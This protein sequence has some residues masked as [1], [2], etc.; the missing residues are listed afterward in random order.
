MIQN[1]PGTTGYTKMTQHEPDISTESTIPT[2]KMKIQPILIQ[3]E[4]GSPR[5]CLNEYST[6]TNSRGAWISAQQNKNLFVISHSI[7]SSFWGSLRCV[8]ILQLRPLCSIGYK[9]VRECENIIYENRELSIIG[10]GIR[11][12]FDHRKEF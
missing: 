7:E 1:D 10:F 12:I 4:L 6:N 9:L 11:E 2:T 3:G 5:Y 8:T